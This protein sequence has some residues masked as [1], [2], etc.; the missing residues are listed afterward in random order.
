MCSY[1]TSLWNED[2]TIWRICFYSWADSEAGEIW[3][4]SKKSRCFG[5]SEPTC[6]PR[7]HEAH[8][9]GLQPHT[10]DAGLMSKVK[11]ELTPH[12]AVA[13]WLNQFCRNSTSP[14]KEMDKQTET[15]TVESDSQ[16]NAEKSLESRWNDWLRR[17]RLKFKAVSLMSTIG[18][19]FSTAPLDVFP[20]DG[21]LRLDSF[22]SEQGC[23]TQR[24]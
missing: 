16:C 13:L 19:H 23:S 11:P 20:H 6:A 10:L 22:I 21:V 15:T 8:R 24:T 14:H 5:A 3:Q 12:E 9:C 18:A 17:L 1:R 2:L 7:Y 4:C